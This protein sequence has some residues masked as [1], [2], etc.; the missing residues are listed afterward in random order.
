MKKKYLNLTL[1]ILFVVVMTINS[2]KA[3]GLMG[4][5]ENCSSDTKCML[6]YTTL[7][8]SEGQPYC[9]SKNV[10]NEQGKAN[11]NV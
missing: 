5:N 7:T 2:P 4:S 9:C 10:Q 1:G 3:F 11:R 8:D 6:H